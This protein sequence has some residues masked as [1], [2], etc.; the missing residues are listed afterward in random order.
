MPAETSA[1]QT[2][3]NTVQNNFHQAYDQIINFARRASWRCWWSSS[4]AT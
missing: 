1:A 3:L 2:A 4:S